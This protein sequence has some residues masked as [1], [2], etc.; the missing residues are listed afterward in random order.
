[1]R[2]YLKERLQEQSTWFG[3]AAAAAALGYHINPEL[4]Q[5]ILIILGITHASLPE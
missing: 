3:I 5:A 1:M 4:I 2:K